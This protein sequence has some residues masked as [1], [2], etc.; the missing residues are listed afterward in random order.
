MLKLIP[1][2]INNIK[3]A[4]IEMDVSDQ[5]EYLIDDYEF[6]ANKPINGLRILTKGSVDFSINGVSKTLFA[7]DT[8]DVRTEPPHPLEGRVLVTAL[9]PSIYFCIDKHVDDIAERTFTT[10]TDN[11]PITVDA[12]LIVVSTM[13]FTID[14]VNVAESE[15]FCTTQISL[16]TAPINARIATVRFK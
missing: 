10:V 8:L 4:C 1:K 5:L 11:S 15:V 7:G 16:I 12:N 13:P 3:V 9:E 14:G 6:Q 2:R